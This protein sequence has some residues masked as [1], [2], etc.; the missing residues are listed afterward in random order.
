MT[1]AYE[2]MKRARVANGLDATPTTNGVETMPPPSNG[3]PAA[4]LQYQKVRVWL[5]T[6]ANRGQRLQTVMVVGCRSGSGSTTTATLL[7]STLAEGQKLRI[8]IV[9]G[10]FRTPS[11]SRVYN[12]RNN[13]G[14]SEVVRQGAPLETH[15][16]KTDQSNLAVLPTGHISR[17]PAE[18]FEGNSLDELLERLKRE[19]DFIIFDA[20]P[21]LEF[22]DAYALAP[23]VDAI[24]LV[25]EAD[26]TSIADAQRAKRDL[27]DAGGRLLGVVLN[28]QKRHA[29]SWLRTRFGIDL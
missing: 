7:A 6:S 25:L 18:V 28:R 1:R 5:T 15:V 17:Y 19:F 20:A 9:D 29:P 21:L 11:L 3:A 24:I 23:K 2:A 4:D 26:R 16:Q 10:N 13:G 14:F 27:E 22:P 12:V 8:L